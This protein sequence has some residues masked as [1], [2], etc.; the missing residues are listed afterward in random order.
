MN[1]YMKVQSHIPNAGQTIV[2]KLVSNMRNICCTTTYTKNETKICYFN[3]LPPHKTTTECPSSIIPKKIW[4][5]HKLHFRGNL[6]RKMRSWQVIQISL[7]TFWY[8]TP[9]TKLWIHHRVE[10][11][12]FL[13][14][15]DFTWNQSWLILRLKTCHFNTFRA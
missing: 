4:I 10:I 14:H 3:Y 15:S 2:S 7:R 8:W 11:T 5:A 6:V 13:R 1:Y 9:N 12:E